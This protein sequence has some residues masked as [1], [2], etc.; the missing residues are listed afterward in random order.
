MLLKDIARRLDLE[1]LCLENRL[2][3]EVSRGYVSD[4][5]SDVLANTRAGDLWITLQ[6][7]QNI[8]A[9]ASM[10]G[11]AG[12]V[13]INGRKPE[14]A[15]IEKAMEEKVPLLSSPLPAFEIAG[16]LYKMGISGT[17]EDAEGVQG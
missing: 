14:K 11:L 8:L 3:C 16:K 4:L 12:I 10:N 2:D 17:G 15:V 1:V 6:T 5:L 13:L 9:V 7:H